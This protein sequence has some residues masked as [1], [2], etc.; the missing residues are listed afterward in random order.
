MKI[1]KIDYGSKLYPEQ[2]YTIYNP[3][4]ILYALGNVELLKTHM[5][6]M[7][8]TRIPTR[9]GS[10]CAITIAKELSNNGYTIVSGLAVGIDQ[11]SHEGALLGKSKATIAVLGNSV[12][13]NDLYPKENE[14]LYKKILYENGLII[15]EYPLGIKAEKWHFPERNRIISGLAEKLIVVEASKHSGTSITV[16]CALDQGKDVYAVPGNIDSV[17]SE[18]CNQLISQGAYIFTSISD[19]IQ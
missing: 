10:N 11:F 1:I 16:E 7:V 14:Y 12:D 15:S 2:L 9:Y 3:P 19:V 13:I 5:I 17:K 18:G 6:A 8:G 4:K